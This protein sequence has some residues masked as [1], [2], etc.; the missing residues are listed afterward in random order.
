[1]RRNGKPQV[2]YRAIRLV[3]EP[4]VPIDAHPTLG[5]NVN[6]PSLMHVPEWI[7]GRLGRYYLYF[8]HHK[9]QFIRLAYADHL[10]GP[11]RVHGPGTLALEDS[12]CYDHVGSPD[13]HVDHPT[14]Q[15]R[16]YFHGPALTKDEARKDPSRKLVPLLGTQRTKVALGSDGLNFRAQ[17]DCLGPSYFRVFRHENWWYALAIPG[18]FLRS[19]DG[20][21]DWEIGPVL[22]N[23]NMRHS[24]V[25][26]VGDTL[27]IFYTRA[28][29]R[30]ERI[31]LATVDLRD[32]WCSWR[33]S[34]PI[35]V[36]RPERPWEG[37]DKPAEP[38]R[39]GAVYGAV[40]Q[41]RD[42][43]IYEE[44]GQVF[45]VYSVAGEQ[46]LGIARLEPVGA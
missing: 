8:A 11:W 7:P 39:R 42:P 43:A 6:G 37:A 23:R 24:A 41:L 2:R 20:I 15:I 33:E 3:D 40:R 10:E 25:R 36:M 5:G 30:P 21:A 45:L 18:V 13:V 32:D 27:E 14:R 35:E 26:V 1:M 34:W 22:F 9:G 19:R 16:M 4:I 31:L 44:N 29:D 38:S 12:T 28:G 17:A 46:G